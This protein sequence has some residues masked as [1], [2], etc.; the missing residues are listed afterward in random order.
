MSVERQPTTIAELIVCPK[1]ND[2]VGRSKHDG[3]NLRL[4]AELVAPLAPGS[5]RIFVRVLRDLNESFSI[6]LTYR[7]SPAATDTVLLRLNGD[8][9]THVNP[10]RSVVAPGP[11]V[12]YFREPL[13]SAPPRPGAQMKWATAISATYLSAAYTRVVT[14]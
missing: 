2:A 11:H 1:S 5:F 14:R 13:W 8:H 4:D 12:H 7:T 9:G 10:D 3:T 6:G